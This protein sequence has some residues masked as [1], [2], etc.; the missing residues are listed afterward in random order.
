MSGIELT[1]GRLFGLSPLSC[2]PALG[3]LPFWGP[4]PR[5]HLPWA[6]IRLTHR[7]GLADPI[8]WRLLFWAR[9]AQTPACGGCK[10][11]HVTRNVYPVIPG[12]WREGTHVLN[13]A[14]IYGPSSRI[15]LQHKSA[16]LTTKVKYVQKCKIIFLKVKR[17]VLATKN[18]SKNNTLRSS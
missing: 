5:L 6:P 11:S 13:G 10:P 18:H 9:V 7:R 14:M 16:D 12:Y 17:K 4:L 15:D 3:S 8:V 1:K 2:P